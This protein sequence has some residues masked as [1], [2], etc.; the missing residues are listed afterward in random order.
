MGSGPLILLSLH[1]RLING[2]ILIVGHAQLKY[3]NFQQDVFRLTDAFARID[4]ISLQNLFPR[5]SLSSTDSL[6][7]TT[8]L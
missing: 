3:I 7:Q 1:F 2:L 6:L 8:A 5:I 4:P